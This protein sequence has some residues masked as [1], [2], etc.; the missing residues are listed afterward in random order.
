MFSSCFIGAGRMT[1]STLFD[2][3][4]GLVVKPSASGAE[5]PGF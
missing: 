4:V 5:D 1:N 3:L 2:R